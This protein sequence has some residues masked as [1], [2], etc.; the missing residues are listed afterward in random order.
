MGYVEMQA[1]ILALLNLPNEECM[2]SLLQLS[3]EE[4][5]QRFSLGQ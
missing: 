3:R 1:I 4:L 2:R 5:L